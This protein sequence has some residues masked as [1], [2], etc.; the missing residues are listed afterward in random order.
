MTSVSCSSL[1]DL[2][3]RLVRALLFSTMVCSS[4]AWACAA[5]CILP[6]LHSPAPRSPTQPM[7]A[8]HHG[9]TARD[10]APAERE[11]RPSNT[12]ARPTST[13]TSLREKRKREKEREERRRGEERGREEER[14]RRG[15]LVT[16]MYCVSPTTVPNEY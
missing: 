9:I 6:C 11:D 16:M 12:A 5:L 14:E 10:Q 1:R 4:E 7:T 8:A 2:R 13:A 15:L 3:A